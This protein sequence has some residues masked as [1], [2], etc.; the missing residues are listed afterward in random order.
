M[1]TICQSCK[2]PV[3]AIADCYCEGSIQC[4]DPTC[5]KMFSSKTLALAKTCDSCRLSICPTCVKNTIHLPPPD[6]PNQMIQ[7]YNSLFNI[8]F[9]NY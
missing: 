8:Y 5:K 6:K 4:R 3:V 9:S 7:D 2:L 1:E